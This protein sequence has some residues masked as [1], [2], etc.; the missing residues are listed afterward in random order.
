[1]QEVP[2]NAEESPLFRAK[3][4]PD[5]IVDEPRRPLK[6]SKYEALSPAT[7]SLLKSRDEYTNTSATKK[8][9]AQVE[10]E[11]ERD[12]EIQDPYTAALKVLPLITSIQGKESNVRTRQQRQEL[13]LKRQELRSLLAYVT[14]RM[15]AM[16]WTRKD[17]QKAL[18]GMLGTVG[19]K[20]QS[21]RPLWVSHGAKHKLREG[22]SVIA[23]SQGS[24]EGKAIAR[25]VVGGGG[26]GG[27]VNYTG[28]LQHAWSTINEDPARRTE[29]LKEEVE[30]VRKLM[31][32]IQSIEQRRDLEGPT[33]TKQ[34]LDEHEDAVSALQRVLV[35]MSASPSAAVQEVVKAET[36]PSETVWVWRNKRPKAL[37][38]SIVWLNDQT[39]KLTL[40]LRPEKDDPA[41]TQAKPETEAEDDPSIE[42]L[43]AEFDRMKTVIAELQRSEAAAPGQGKANS[44]ARAVR[45]QAEENWSGELRKMLESF[46][47]S[48]EKG[49]HSPSSVR[50]SLEAKMGPPGKFWVRKQPKDHQSVIFFKDEEKFELVM[51]GSKKASGN[52]GLEPKTT[53]IA[54][55]AGAAK[56]SRQEPP[57]QDRRGKDSGKWSEKDYDK[58]EDDSETPLAITYTTAASTFIYGSNSVLAALSAKRRKLYHLYLQTRSL[59][60]EGNADQIKQL[61]RDAKVPTTKDANLALLDKMSGRR[62]H[63]GVVLEASNLPTPPVLGLGKPDSRLSI[64][65]LNLQRQSAE[66]VAINGAPAALPSLTDTWRHPFVLMLDGITD[67]GNMGNIIRTAHFY[68]VDAVAVATNTCASVNSSVVAK[69]SS[70]AVE[71][72]QILALPSPS[73]FVYECAKN[74]WRVYAATPPLPGRTPSQPSSATAPSKSATRY[75]TASSVTAN[76]PLAKHACVLMLGAEGEGLRDNLKNRADFFVSIAQGKRGVSVPGVGVDSVNVG[77]AAGVLVESFLRKPAGAMN[78]MVESDLGF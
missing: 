34:L 33:P 77:V 63:N 58:A 13:Y 54:A 17:T 5:A 74:R 59:S 76:S 55:N 43:E 12:S 46:N 50:R 68:G 31:S 35:T 72:V 62:P 23:W 78:L 2:T 26:G 27:D 69:A 29:R 41:Q 32:D 51:K 60:R 66:D 1:M 39:G 42:N 57:S 70:G 48:L 8:R 38:K 28:L 20:S 49:K 9:V 44:R 4:L 64:I 14:A 24:E 10:A 3:V 36:N 61:A 6:I 53:E 73:N 67:E 65:P 52:E 37:D 22:Q 19:H 75:V 47:R 30:Q 7:R 71:A 15:Q 45:K 56:K 21:G 16:Q 18:K 11:Q 25:L 40:V